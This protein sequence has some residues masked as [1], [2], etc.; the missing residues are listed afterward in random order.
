MNHRDLEPYDTIFL[1]LI[2]LTK[3]VEAV[4]GNE[5]PLFEALD[6][7][8]VIAI[9]RAPAGW[10]PEDVL[11]PMRVEELDLNPM[12]LGEY[13]VPLEELWQEFRQAL[14]VAFGKDLPEEDTDK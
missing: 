6:E 12:R 11:E 4:L 14:A 9:D 10:H 1:E 7:A 5:S 3:R 13:G 8:R 2:E